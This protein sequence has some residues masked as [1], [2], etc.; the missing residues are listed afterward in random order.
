MRK[1]IVA[2]LT[3]GLLAAGGAA[4]RAEEKGGEGDGKPGWRGHGPFAELTAEQRAAMK[5]AHRSHRDAVTPLKDKLEDELEKLRGLVEKAAPEK[6][7]S[8]SVDKV[9]ELHR[10]IRAER[11]KFM[12]K[13]GASLTPLQRAKGVLMLERR[14]KGAMAGH[15]FGKGRGMKGHGMRGPRG[16]GGGA[17][18]GGGGGGGWRDAMSDD[19][20]GPEDVEEELEVEGPGP[21]LP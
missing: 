21:E 7:L 13:M 5:A 1:L 6:D 4:L 19:E 18:R 20:D 17:P 8:A 10:S 14:M 12:D 15:F 11:E 2:V 16:G 3:C 9:K